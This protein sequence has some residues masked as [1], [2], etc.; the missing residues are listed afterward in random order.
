MEKKNGEQT[1]KL[2]QE[3]KVLQKEAEGLFRE[4]HFT[5]WLPSPGSLAQREKYF[6]SKQGLNAI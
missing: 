1:E 5:L 4:I 2:Q 6:Y 3:I